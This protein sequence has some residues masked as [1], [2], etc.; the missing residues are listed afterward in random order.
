MTHKPTYR[1]QITE[2]AEIFPFINP[3]LINR[4]IFPDKD[5]NWCKAQ[6]YAMLRK[7]KSEDFPRIVKSLNAEQ[8]MVYVRYGNTRRVG[9]TEFWHNYAVVDVLMRFYT[10]G[11]PVKYHN[12]RHGADGSAGDYHIEV[13]KSGKGDA[14]LKGQVMKLNGIPG[15]KILYVVMAPQWLRRH[16]HKRQFEILNGLRE[17]VKDMLDYEDRG[18]F[19][20]TTYAKASDPLTNPL[21]DSIWRD[22]DGRFWSLV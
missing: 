1:D 7:R 17:K 15:E 14:A 18:K 12:K 22:C 5:Y 16:D 6:L 4:H 20:F 2:L 9:V 8:E 21:T 3:T 11:L 19:L 13:Y 10:L